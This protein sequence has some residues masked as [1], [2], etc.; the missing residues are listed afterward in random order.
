MLALNNVILGN[1]IQMSPLRY[2]VELWFKLLVFY[3]MSQVD[4]A[5]VPSSPK[6]VFQVPSLM[7]NYSI[8]AFYG[9]VSF[10]DV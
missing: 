1:L 7:R 4:T 10:W 8:L 9:T 2:I 6:T 5:F 3:S